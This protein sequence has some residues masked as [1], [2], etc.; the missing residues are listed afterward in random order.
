MLIGSGTVSSGSRGRPVFGSNFLSKLFSIWNFRIPYGLHMSIESIRNSY[1]LH[2]EFIPL[3]NIAAADR[4]RVRRRDVG[5][6]VGAEQV[7]CNEQSK[8][9]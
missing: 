3:P 7:V 9:N 8:M 6:G 1:G 2:M 4:A 5:A